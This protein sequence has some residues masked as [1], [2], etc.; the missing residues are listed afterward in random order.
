MS[1][2]EEDVAAPEQQEE[3]EDEELPTAANIDNDNED[4]ACIV[5]QVRG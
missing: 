5:T 2:K 1:A 4:P 3:E